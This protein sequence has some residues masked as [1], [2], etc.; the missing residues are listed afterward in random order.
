MIL[1]SLESLMFHILK[2]F[3]YIIVTYNLKIIYF[4]RD[5]I[6]I[7]VFLKNTYI[8]KKLMIIIYEFYKKYF[9]KL[10]LKYLFIY[11][12]NISKLDPYNYLI[13]VL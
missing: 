10:L 6:H 3:A 2:L 13:L 4:L 8:L 11:F 12:N 7:D 9:I 1:I 5:V